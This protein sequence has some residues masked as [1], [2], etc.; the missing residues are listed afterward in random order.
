[1]YYNIIRFL[2]YGYIGLVHV[3]EPP[4]NPIYIILLWSH[5]CFVFRY[6]FF[7]FEIHFSLFHTQPPVCVTVKPFLR[8]HSGV[9]NRRFVN[10]LRSGF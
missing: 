2:F 8:V 3:H 7:F 5:L 4:K 9:L 1:M 6:G 10:Y